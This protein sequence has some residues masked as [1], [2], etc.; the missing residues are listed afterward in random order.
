MHADATP[1]Q[2]RHRFLAA[3]LAAPTAMLGGTEAHHAL[4]VL[5]LRAGDRVEL[6]DG[7]GRRGVGTIRAAGRAQVEVSLERVEG[8][9]PRPAPHVHLAVAM[10]KGNRLDWLLEKASELGA[11]SI[12]P[13]EAARSVVRVRDDEAT[14][15]RWSA[16]AAGA[17]RQSRQLHLPEI[18]PPRDLAAFLADERAGARLIGQGGE[19]VPPLAEVLGGM[20]TGAAV[21]AVARAALGDVTLL[22]GPEGGWTDDELAEA[23]GAAFRPVRLGHSVL[24]VETAAVALLAGVLALAAG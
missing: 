12:R 6:F 19:D 3:D 17:I 14:R 18:L 7:R 24:R 15:Q 23:A 13:I 22:V 10:P 4:H 2:P 21:P 16:I 20:A 11:A 8:P 5:R 1:D 9:H